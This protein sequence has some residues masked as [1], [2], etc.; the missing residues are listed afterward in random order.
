MNYLAAGFKLIFKPGI[1]LY[2]F[3]PFLINTAIFICLF[4]VAKSYFGK[5]NDWAIHFLPNWLSWLSTILW[6]IFFIGFIFVAIYTF[7]F[8]ANIIAAPFNSILSEKVELYLTGKTA[9]SQGYLGIIKDVPR[10]IL[11]QVA[12]LGHFLPRALVLLVMFLI[13][14]LQLAAPFLWFL[15]QAWIMALQYLDYP[16]DNHKIPFKA[17]VEKASDKRLLS[18]SFGGSVFIC[19]MIPFVNFLVLPAACAGATKLWVDKLR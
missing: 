7:N 10:V 14:V 1:R 12:I 19:S 9:N 2:A 4:F 15:F 5:F 3:I 6:F 8:I 17:V 18:L 11:R 13:P 16:T